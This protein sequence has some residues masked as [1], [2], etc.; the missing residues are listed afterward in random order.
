MQLDRRNRREILALLGG[1]AAW[2]FAAAAQ[3]RGLPR[4]LG[5]L[6]GY[7]ENDAE[8]LARVAAFKERLANLGWIESR[9]LRTELRWSAG[10]IG[11]ASELARELVAL[12]PDVILANAT[13]STAA[14][15]RETRRIPVVFVPASD[16][17][18]SGFVESLARPGGNITGFINLESTLIQKWLEL[19]KEIAPRVTRAAVIFNPQT[20]PY[21]DYYLRSLPSAA[22]KLGVATFAAPV[23]DQSGIASLVA[24]LAGEAGGGL[25]VMTDSGM[26]VHR[27]TIIEQAALH[28]VPAIYWVSNIPFE[29]GLLSYG[30]DYVDLF[31]R[32]A[33]YVDRILRGARPQDLPVQQPTRFELVVNVKAATALGLEVPPALLARADE[34]IE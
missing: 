25:V 4:R 30:V 15:Q 16:P 27:R 1:G 6:M 10:D 12:Q 18:G 21:A 20:A 3:E 5:V 8:G 7:A 9:N 11:R 19:L 24:S 13:P 31:R 29:G 32:A 23:A 28:K 2:P 22:E 33:T 26:F 17:I 34:V 14:V